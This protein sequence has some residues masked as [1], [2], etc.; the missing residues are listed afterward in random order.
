MT[1]NTG[2][3]N[4]TSV[5]PCLSFTR[6]KDNDKSGKDADNDMLSF[7]VQSLSQDFFLALVLYLMLCTVYY[8]TF[9]QSVQFSRSVVSDSLQPHGL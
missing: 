1:L 4:K 7:S 5:L 6:K 9:S 3:L 2:N 8:F